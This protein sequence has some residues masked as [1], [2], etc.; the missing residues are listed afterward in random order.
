MSPY[1]SLSHPTEK[2]KESHLCRIQ[3]EEHKLTLKAS[4]LLLM[5]HDSSTLWSSSNITLD[6]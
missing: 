5:A 2:Q 6:G 3:I 1:H 4:L